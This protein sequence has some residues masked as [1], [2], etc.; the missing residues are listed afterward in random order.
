MIAR[1]VQ[2]FRTGRAHLPKMEN[3]FLIVMAVA[4]AAWIIWDRWQMKHAP[5]YRTLREIRRGLEIAEFSGQNFEAQEWRAKL[6][7]MDA[8]LIRK[9]GAKENPKSPKYHKGLANLRSEHIAF[10]M[11]LDISRREHIKYA[12][13]L[14]QA[15]AGLFTSGDTRHFRSMEELPYPMAEI[16]KAV[17]AMLRYIAQSEPQAEAALSQDYAT[18]LSGLAES[19]ERQYLPLS[20]EVLAC[21]GREN[22]RVGLDYL[23]EKE[24][25]NSTGNGS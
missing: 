21:T 6:A 23:R 14:V 11:T 4:V 7:W 8:L 12:D 17:D 18:S 2:Q 16:L 3:I 19:L 15:L 24:N 5:Y 13:I 20:K 22:M 25:G 1:R 9:L 10:P